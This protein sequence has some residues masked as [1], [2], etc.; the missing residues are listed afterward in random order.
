[1]LLLAEVRNPRATRLTEEFALDFLILQKS[2]A[3]LCTI[4]KGGSKVLMWI[5]LWLSV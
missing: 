1:M 4:E 2:E 3:A 5:E